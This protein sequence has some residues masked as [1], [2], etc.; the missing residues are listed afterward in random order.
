MTN[1][2]YLNIINHVVHEDTN[3]AGEAEEESEDDEQDSEAGEEEIQ[4]EEQEVF[5]VVVRITHI[6]TALHCTSDPPEQTC[7]P[8]QTR[9]LHSHWS[10]S[11]Q[12]LSYDWWNL[13]MLAPSSMP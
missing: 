9:G 4:E 12:I 6:D 2:L 3:P 7:A 5:T 11:L 13:T 8:P 1:I 10:R